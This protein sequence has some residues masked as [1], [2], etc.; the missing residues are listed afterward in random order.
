MY[1]EGLSYKNKQFFFALIKI[2][3]VVIAFYFIYQKLTNNKILY[4]SDFVEILSKN[5]VFSLKTVA[6]L[7]ILTGFNWFFEIL[8][9]QQLVSS[10]QKISFKKS[11][12]QCLGP[13]TVSLF[14]PNRIGEY[15]AKALY[16]SSTFRKRV[17]LINVINNLL[18]MLVTVI[19][20]LIG[21]LLLSQSQNLQINGL[22][23]IKILLI[24]I[25]FCTL[26]I[27]IIRKTNIKIR[28]FSLES[29]KL[30]LFKFPKKII[31]LGLLFSLFRY[32][33]FSFQFFYLLL[34]FGVE[35]SYIE[36]MK[37]ITSM[38]FLASIIPSIF[39][40]DVV[41]KGSVA[42]YL[43]SLIGINELVILSIVTCMWILNFV[44][45]SIIGGFYVLHF[46]LPKNKDR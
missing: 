34:L 14:T 27:L 28:G 29:L 21:M 36:A 45:P 26:I 22:K 24:G 40:F 11:L 10:V 8:K 18:Q 41:I 20:G 6:F 46:K 39:L 25:S 32:L 44:T 4:F 2:S 38:Y 12:E 42:L 1:F 37:F 23:F 19:F 17:L 5:K 33:I 9:W 3:L 30:F 7:M 16:F 35:I 31:T 43:F 13:L 15:G